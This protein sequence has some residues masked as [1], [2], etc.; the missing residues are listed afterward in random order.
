M[1]R[2]RTGTIEK[3]D[4]EWFARITVDG[5]NRKRIKLG[6]VS[7]ARAR[8]MLA[9]LVERI[10]KAALTAPTKGKT[11]TGTTVKQWGE[12]WTSG[13]LLERYGTVN[14]LKVKKS[15]RD[16]VNRLRRYVYKTIGNMPVADVTDADI[17]RVMAAVPA[18]RRAA[19]HEKV[20]LLVH[21]MFD[22]AIV[23]GRLR[24]DNPVTRYH[25][26]RRDAAK[27]FGY[28][29]PTE[30]SMLLK[31][32]LVPTERKVAYCIGCYVGLRKGS[33]YGLRWADV[34]ET[35]GT[36]TVRVTKSG[37]PLLFEIQPGL[38]WVLKKW[39]EATDGKPGDAVVP[40]RFKKDVEATVLRDDLRAAGVTREVLFTKTMG[41][42]PL[43]FHDLRAT[44]VTWA[45][46]AGKGDG[47]ISDRTGHLSPGMIERYSR[48]A[49]TLADLHM[50]P[51]PE[52]AEA[53]P[54]LTLGIVPQ[55]SREP[56][57]RSR[58]AANKG[59]KS[60]RFQAQWPR[61]DSNRHAFPGRG[62]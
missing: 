32:P 3:R 22:L 12:D 39:R 50:E 13:K 52:L 14:G 60:E 54:E 38:R 21:R 59:A 44:F 28:L 40:R 48:A 2:K 26:P 23:P 31:S 34:D 16:D 47:W 62:F 41:I 11:P 57:K 33:L 15:V 61:P 45:K 1:P 46:R 18:A 42:E 5:N 8:E 53:I 30:F 9:A 19:T 36:L 25:R 6:K 43:R 56:V 51:F 27:L 10:N 58:K 49:R 29:L 20:Y 4:G 17:D 55:T 24:K 37:V 7:E 35:N